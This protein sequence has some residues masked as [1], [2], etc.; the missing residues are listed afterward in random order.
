[1]DVVVWARINTILLGLASS[2]NAF[3][4]NEYF[5]IPRAYIDPNKKL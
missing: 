3:I 4:H 2:K 1:M 5:D